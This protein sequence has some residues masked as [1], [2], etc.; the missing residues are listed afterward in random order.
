MMAFLV[1]SFPEGD[2][3]NDPKYVKWF[4]EFVL[5]V[6]GEWS[7]GEVPMHVCT[8]EDMSKFH[9]PNKA[10]AG[11]VNRY[12]DLGGFMCLD[13]RDVPLYGEDPADNSATIDVM[14]LPCG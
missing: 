7:Y 5:Q 1:T 9:K 12:K 14:F 4:A 11:L 6:D 8:E 10:S 3:K 13:M 2:I